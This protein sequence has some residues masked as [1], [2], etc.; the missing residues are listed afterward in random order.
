[1]FAHAPAPRFQQLLLGSGNTAAAAA[2]TAARAAA[3]TH[4]ALQPNSS[5][6]SW[7]RHDSTFDALVVIIF[8]VVAVSV[9]F[10]G[11]QERAVWACAGELERGIESC[12]AR[13][14]GAAPFESYYLKELPSQKG[15]CTY[16]SKRERQS[17]EGVNDSHD[18]MNVWANKE[19]QK[20]F[21]SKTTN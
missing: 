3:N 17:L 15:V 7:R 20:V 10:V 9:A 8:V 2:A 19:K 4:A 12:E 11:A 13:P 18:T 14:L 5:S 1:V 6:S 21:L 16:T